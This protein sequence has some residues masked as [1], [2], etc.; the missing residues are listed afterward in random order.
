MHNK[1]LLC[2][3]NAKYIHSNLAVRYLKK[4]CESGSGKISIAEFSIND[5]INNILKAL[6]SFDAEIYGFSCY[7]WNIRMLLDICSSLRKAKPSAVIILGGPEVSYDP[8]S[9]LEANDFIDYLVVGEGEASFLELLS[10]LASGAWEPEG[11]RGIAYRKGREIVVTPPRPL[12]ADM[13]TIP[14]PYDGLEEFCNRIVY[15]E[16][17]RGC[18]F[19]CRYCLSSTIPGVRFLSMERL[20]RDIKRFAE[21]GV[22][23]VKLVDRTFNCDIE[24]AVEIMEYIIGLNP[25]T[26]FHFELAADLIDE[27]FLETVKKAP[28]GLFQ[29]EIGVQSTNRPTLSE[30]ERTM[31]FDRVSSNVRELI[32][33]GNT[34]I[35]LDL[36]AGLPF[37][38]MAAFRKSFNDVYALGPDMLQLGF[39]KLL[40]GS[41]IREDSSDYGM[42]YHTFPPYEVIKTHWLS[43]RELLLLKDL[44]QVLEHYHNSG[45]FRHTLA[46]LLEA[47][48]A[49]PFDFFLELAC[50]W[51]RK[52]YFNS[53]RNTNEL[54]IIMKQFAGEIYADRLKPAQF[55]LLNE[56]LKLDWLL[57]TRSGSMPE[58]I[59]RFDHTPVKGSIQEYI[60]KYLTETEG[61]T[62]L[63]AAS[64]RELLKQI[65]YEVFTRDV[66]KGIPGS[67]ELVLFFPL[68]PASCGKKPFYTVIPLV[69]VLHKVQN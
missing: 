49:E 21:A 38:D 20:R 63:R 27:R 22:R 31:D 9:I 26:N 44:E 15:Y 57:F 64:M 14:Y 35:H 34:H 46:F 4:Y 19:N 56:C 18:P 36:I 16:T 66:F 28:A 13:D 67:A 42:E 6:Y 24:R 32:S 17:S 5:S 2:A 1:V 58:A 53:S 51:N 39:L 62:G 37:E 41:G 29:F 52:S 11:I 69:E 12:I 47:S 45:R 50:F 23:Q 8:E 61:F 60:R 25:S 55:S 65:G 54:Y 7:I 43:Y 68:K 48:K 59:E 10:F 3:V 30:I 40:K 33:Y